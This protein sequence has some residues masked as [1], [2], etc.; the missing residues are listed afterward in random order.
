MR[1]K[2][3]AALALAALLLCTMLNLEPPSRAASTDEL[4]D[5]IGDMKEQAA[6]YQAQQKELEQKLADIKDQTSQSEELRT[7][8]AQQLSAIQGQ[9]DET[10]MQL[11]QY[12]LLIG[13]TQTE[14]DSAKAEEA[15]ATQTFYTMARATEEMGSVSYLSVLFQAKSWSEMLDSFAMVDEIMDYSDRLVKKLTTAKEAVAVKLSELQSA[16][17]EMAGTAEEL[18]RQKAEQQSAVDRINAQLQQLD[19]QSAHTQAEIDEAKTKEAAA[20]QAQKDAQKEIARLEAEAR[21]QVQSGSISIDPGS[22]WAWPLPGYTRITS[23]FGYRTHPISG[24]YSLHRGV[25]IG[26]PNGTAIHAARGGVVIVSGVHSSYGNYVVLSH[27]DGIDTLY[28]HLSSRAVS[29]G[30]TV[31]QNAVLGYVGSTG[32]STGN[33]LHFE[34]HVNGTLVDPLNYY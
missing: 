13:Q 31:A 14:L 29:R 11:T 17:A 18:D 20:E 25:D 26:A 32:S 28:A 1:R 4:R 6:A 27:G 23:P 2:R 7:L 9:I 15:A 12:E 24:R 8:A 10:Q 34:V 21:K 30:Q 22:G 5:K 19:A 3:A 16:Q 33:H